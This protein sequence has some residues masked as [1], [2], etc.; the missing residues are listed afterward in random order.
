LVVPI[1]DTTE[2]Q[3]R[4]LG[5]INVEHR[6]VNAFSERDRTFL[7][8]LAVQSAI[9]LRTI[10]LYGKLQKQVRQALSL[11]TIAARR[12]L[13]PVSGDAPRARPEGEQHGELETTLRLILTGVTASDGLEHS[14]AMLLEVDEDSRELK[15]LIGLGAMTRERAEATW[16]GV[17]AASLDMLLGWAEGQAE[18]AAPRDSGNEFNQCVRGVR[19]SLDSLQGPLREWIVAGSSTVCYVKGADFDG[20][21]L[22]QFYA[23]A[24]HCAAACA[25]LRAGR[26]VVGLLVVDNRFLF[27]EQ[28]LD[29]GGAPILVAFAELAAMAIEGARLRARLADEGQLRNWRDT[30]T[31][32]AHVLKRRLTNIDALEREVSRLLDH[33]Q[34]RAARNTLESLKHNLFEMMKAFDRIQDFGRRQ[35]LRKKRVDLV[36]AVKKAVESTATSVRAPIKFVLPQEAVYVQ[37]DPERLHDILVELFGNADCAMRSAGTPEPAIHV[38]VQ[39][40]IKE[41][42]A[43]VEVQD[44]GPGVPEEMQPLMFEPYVTDSLVSTG[45]GLA[46][47]K[48]LVDRH[49]GTIVYSPDD[50]TGGARFIIRVPAAASRVAAGANL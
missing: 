7:E 30:S 18:T 2:G 14:R 10:E 27:T 32:V 13:P 47:I 50:T 44:N 16:S 43:E 23:G 37:A 29:P 42:M 19:I 49:D 5:V 15:G 1:V 40:A 4:L 45:L 17:G 12:V 20:G 22:S 8:T 11:G 31:R 21:P 26:K 9:G 38:S 3:E 35:E 39:H 6:N 24:T 28:N 25:P 46:I 36:E 34:L 33:L 48:D 41:G